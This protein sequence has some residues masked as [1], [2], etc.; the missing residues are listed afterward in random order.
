MVNKYHRTIPDEHIPDVLKKKLV[1]GDREQIV[2]LETLEN[3]PEE[4]TFIVEIE[5]TGCYEIE[6]KARTDREAEKKARGQASAYD[7]DDWNISVRAIEV[8]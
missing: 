8:K 6:I 4:K 5:F 1:F 7:V 3:L 2:A